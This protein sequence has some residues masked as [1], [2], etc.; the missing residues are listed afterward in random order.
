MGIEFET[1]NTVTIPGD[2][3]TAGPRDYKGA[4][5]MGRG[6][7]LRVPLSE[8]EFSLVRWAANR[9]AARSQDHKGAGVRDYRNRR[10]ENRAVALDLL[11][12]RAIFEAVRRLVAAVAIGG[13]KIPPGVAQDFANWKTE[14]M[15]AEN[16]NV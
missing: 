16:G 7:I 4:G 8:S 10:G 12:R 3:G 9:G 13:G 2:H 6:K 1:T 5:A 11:G 15:K 14:M